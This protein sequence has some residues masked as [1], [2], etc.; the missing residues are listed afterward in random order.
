MEVYQILKMQKLIN[1]G[2]DKIVVNTLIHKDPKEVTKI[3]DLV[4]SSS[5]VGVIEVD[6]RSKNLSICI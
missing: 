3:I 4:G 2:A 6:T 5:V 1:A